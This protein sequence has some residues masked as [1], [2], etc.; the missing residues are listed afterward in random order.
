[1]QK[2]NNVW[3]VVGV[4]VAIALLMYWLFAGTTLEEETNSEISPV[5]IEQTP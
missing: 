1:M 2:R 5:I 4:I 3:L